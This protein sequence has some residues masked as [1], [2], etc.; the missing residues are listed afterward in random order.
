VAQQVL[1]VEDDTGSQLVS[2]KHQTLL[3]SHIPI[4]TAPNTPGVISG[5]APIQ[6]EQT[7]PTSHQTRPSYD[8]GLHFVRGRE[9][10]KFR[11]EGDTGM[12]R[13][14]PT[15]ATIEPRSAQSST[16]NLVAPIPTGNRPISADSERTGD[17]VFG[18]VA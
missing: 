8:S 4:A 15:S 12:F 18:E 11:A 7:M 9:A 1:L 14:T 10:L 3:S 6:P 13:R 16:S 17:M 5:F 2:E